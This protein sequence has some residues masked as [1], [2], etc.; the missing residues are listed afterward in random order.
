M[1]Q[2]DAA[3]HVPLEPSPEAE[4]AAPDLDTEMGEPL[5]DARCSIALGMPMPE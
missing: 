4:G 2:E 3:L 5:V 1:Q